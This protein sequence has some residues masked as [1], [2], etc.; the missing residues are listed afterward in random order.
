[1][2]NEP[3]LIVLNTIPVR[4]EPED[5]FKRLRL[6]IEERRI[7]DMVREL[8]ELVNEKAVPKAVYKLSKATNNG[9]NIVVEGVELTCWVPTLKFFPDETVYP[10]VATCGAE[11][12][13][14]TSPKSDFLRHYIMNQLKQMVLMT[15]AEYLQQHLIE[16]YKL[17]QLTHVGPG[18]ALGPNEQQRKLFQILGD[19]TGKIGVRLSEHHLMVPE[20]S[21]SGIFFET[22]ERLER[23]LLCPDPKC[24]TRRVPYQPKELL[25]YRV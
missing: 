14:V 17:K 6:R 15:S 9:K 20:K 19:V 8:T 12:D 7:S 2:S 4:L 21:T 1:M 24:A 10:Y 13:E 25:K 22:S 18:E 3:D 16:T 23:C 11:L 5:V